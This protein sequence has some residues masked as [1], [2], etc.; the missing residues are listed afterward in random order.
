MRELAWSRLDGGR[1]HGLALLAYAAITIVMTWPL[2]VSL[3]DVVPVDLG[4][5]LVSASILWWNAQTVP[6]TDAWWNGTFFFPGPDSLALSDHRLGLGLLTT[7]PIWLGASPLDAYAIAFLLTFVLSAASAYALMYTLTSSRAAAFLAGCV[8]GFNPFRADQ[9]AHLEL[10]ASYCLPVILLALHQWLATRRKS[11]LFVLS[12]SLLLQASTSGYYFF[13]MAVL[14]ALWLMWFVRGSLTRREYAELAVAL[15]MPVIAIAPIL[16]RYDRVHDAM[17]LSRSIVE[18]ERYSADVIGLLTAPMTLALWQSPSAWQRPEGALMPGA[19][20]VVVVAAAAWLGRRRVVTEG[21]RP[22]AG[23]FRVV[24]IA[25]VFAAVTVAVLPSL[26]GPV[27]V[28]FAGVRVT[29]SGAYKPLS[30]AVVCLAAWFATSG[31]FVAAFRGRS[32]FAFYSLATVVM[33][34][35]A[36][37]PEVR[38]MGSRIFYKAP[39]SWLMLMPGFRDEFRAPAR[40]AM[41][42][43][44]ALSVAAGLAIW[45]VT[46]QWPSRTRLGIVGVLASVILAESWIHPFPLVAAPAPL[47]VP[48]GIAGSAVML[49]LPVGVYDDALAM[50]HTMAHGRATVNG[51]SGYSPPHYAIFARAIEEGNAGVLTVL[52]QQADVAVFSRRNSPAAMGLMPQVQAAPGAVALAATTTHLVTL[53]PHQPPEGAPATARRSE[54]VKVAALAAHASTE[55][56]PLVTDGDYRTAWISRHPQSGTEFMSVTLAEPRAVSGMRLALGGRVMSFARHIAIDVSADGEN[57]SAVWSG[58]GAVAALAAALRDPKHIEMVFAFEPQRARQVRIR[59]TGQSSDWWAVT[60]LRVL[61]E[62]VH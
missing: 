14:L 44:L 4:D 53:L 11:W 8:F 29:T 21:A 23:R 48:P 26:F 37:G 27:T 40:F 18:I 13:Y 54:E 10:L 60:E 17:G 58:D 55:E 9:L 5:P 61:A 49:E 38:L 51:L 6:F 41:L 31:P 46:Q 39:Y 47:T 56:L 1:R 43:V 35:F 32:T 7:P 22:I 24:M 45:R 57:W 12:G 62:P 19:V 59:Q 20:A 42:A 50:F 34:I 28:D 15:G 2:A 36:F 16:A 3:G 25:G 52:R 30:I 33:W